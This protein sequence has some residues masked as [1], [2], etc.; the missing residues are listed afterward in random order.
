MEMKEEELVEDGK[1]D[2]GGEKADG[3]RRGRREKDINK[4]VEMEKKK[5]EE[6]KKE[7]GM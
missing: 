1:Y 4:M 5:K 3:G 6:K 2:E 7:E